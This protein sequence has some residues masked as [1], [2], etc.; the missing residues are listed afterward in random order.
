MGAVKVS[1]LHFERVSVL[2]HL[3]QEVL[4]KIWMVIKLKTFYSLDILFI[5]ALL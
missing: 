4:D 5:V 3:L 2:V 1:V